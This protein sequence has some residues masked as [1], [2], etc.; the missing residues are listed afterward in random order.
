MARALPGRVWNVDAAGTFPD[1]SGRY[2]RESATRSSGCDSIDARLGRLWNRRTLSGGGKARDVRDARDRRRRPRR[3][4]AP[5]P[6]GR[7][8]S[9]GPCRG[10]K[11]RS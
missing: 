7:R 10:N 1:R 9:G 2:S 5:L 3:E 11:T 4:T 8:L 6:H